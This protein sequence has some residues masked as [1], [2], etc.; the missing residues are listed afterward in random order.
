MI[1]ITFS[2]QNAVNW[3]L[4]EVFCILSMRQSDSSVNRE[5]LVGNG[6]VVGPVLYSTTSAVKSFYE[7]V[8]IF[9]TVGEHDC[10]ARLDLHGTWNELIPISLVF[11]A[12]M[13]SLLRI[14][15]CALFYAT[16]MV[17]AVPKITINL[18]H[19]RVFLSTTIHAGFLSNSSETYMHSK[20]SVQW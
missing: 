6:H 4:C 13:A 7:N 8:S 16:E 5:C 17:Q 15:D 9:M 3:K 11:E 1:W 20:L 2:N 10:L 14:R 19:F 12:S 18:H